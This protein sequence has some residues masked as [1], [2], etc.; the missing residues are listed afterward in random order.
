VLDVSLL[1]RKS[2]R[3]CLARRSIMHRPIGLGAGV[4]KATA[5]VLIGVGSG[6]REQ[7]TL[8]RNASKALR[9]GFAS[10]TCRRVCQAL[11]A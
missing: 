5:Q 9:W 10:G 3:N 8:C 2:L 7:A 6:S 11:T 4:V 1:S